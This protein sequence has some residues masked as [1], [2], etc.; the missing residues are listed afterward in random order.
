[1]T[2]RWVAFSLAFAVAVPCAAQNRFD[3]DS[4]AL[5]AAQLRSTFVFH[6]VVIAR[7]VRRPSDLATRLPTALVLV[8]RVYSAP[9]SSGLFAS[10]SVTV[11]LSDTVG[12]GP[13]VGAD[14]LFYAAGWYAGTQIGLREVMRMDKPTPQE[15]ADFAQYRARLQIG[16][17]EWSLQQRLATADIVVVGRVRAAT[18]I[19]PQ[20]YT[21][22]R[23]EHLPVYRYLTV[24]SLA[25]LKGDSSIANNALAVLYTTSQGYGGL[26]GLRIAPGDRRIFAL[27]RFVASAQPGMPLLPLLPPNQPQFFLPDSVSLRPLADTGT[28]RR[29]LRRP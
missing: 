3:T 2:A 15:L 24:D 1:M 16:Y 4:A 10:E 12:I 8:K 9:A 14:A 27:N 19:D 21:K 20:Q 11:V 26:Y 5:L 28:V 13:S 18:T 17:E 7:N 22:S 25:W 23:D 6:G 29:F